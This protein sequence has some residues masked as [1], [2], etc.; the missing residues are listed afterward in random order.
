MHC[1]RFHWQKQTEKSE[2][3]KSATSNIILKLI[4]TLN[5]PLCTWGMKGAY[6]VWIATKR[7]GSLPKIQM[8]LVKSVLPDEA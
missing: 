6:Y 7:M 3:L 1:E 4:Q 5:T 2:L 8:Y